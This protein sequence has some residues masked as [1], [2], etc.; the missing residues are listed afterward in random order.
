MRDERASRGAEQPDVPDAYGRQGV[1]QAEYQEGEY[2]QEAGGQ[3]GFTRHRPSNS[4]R[5]ASENPVA[6]AARAVGGAVSGL[7]GRI[8]SGRRQAAARG[9]ARGA[10]PRS[11]GGDYLGTGEP[12]RVCGNPVDPSQ[13]RCPHC[14]AFVRPL[15]RSVPFWIAVAV[16]VAVVALLTAGLSSC[17]QSREGDGGP[18]QGA[19]VSTGRAALESAVASAQEVLDAQQAS[20]T[21]T[22][23]TLASLESA[24]AAANAVLADPASTDEQCQASAQQVS[25]AVSA[26]AERVTDPEW[27][28]YEALTAYGTVDLGHQVA[29]N[30][31]VQEISE[32]QDGT[33]SMSIAVSGDP[34]LIVY[35]NFSAAD[36]ASIPSVGQ[37]VNAVGSVVGLYQACAVVL[38]DS[39]EVVG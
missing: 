17:V 13:S 25:A 24:V 30:G 21:Y 6:G 23:Y 34:S 32:A 29:V 12:C 4:R 36:A 22:R 28:S 37:D 18:G 26:L 14:G 10:S 7:V 3:A 16:L 1:Y 38:A 11:E 20:R 33:L 31:T 19:S 15:Y 39:V 9:G 27:P 2:G 8:S 35:V 5:L